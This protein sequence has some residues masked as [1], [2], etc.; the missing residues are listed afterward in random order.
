MPGRGN[1]AEPAFSGTSPRLPPSVN[2]RATAL[3]YHLKVPLPGGRID[4]F[5]DRPKQTQTV[6]IMQPWKIISMTHQRA[7]SCWRGVENC[8][9]ITLDYLPPSIGLWIIQRSFVHHR[10]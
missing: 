6:K 10:G 4:W 3:T 8:H 1:V 2:N 5:T 7:D 9:A